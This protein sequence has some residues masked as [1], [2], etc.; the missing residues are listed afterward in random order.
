MPGGEGV[1][2]LDAPECRANERGTA[3]A[4]ASVVGNSKHFEPP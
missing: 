1:D 4:G 2:A 3:E